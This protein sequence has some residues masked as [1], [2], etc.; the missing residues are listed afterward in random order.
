[1][2]KRN[3]KKVFIVLLLLFLN[4]CSVNGCKV[5][6]EISVEQQQTERNTEQQDEQ[7][8]KQKQKIIEMA[9]DLKD[10]M[11]PGAQVSCTY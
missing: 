5:G 10:N 1:M 3:T 8:P 2:L 6:Y 7:K 4:G 11:T 9:K